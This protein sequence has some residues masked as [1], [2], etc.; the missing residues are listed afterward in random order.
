MFWRN[1]EIVGIDIG[2]RFIKAVEVKESKKGYMLERFGIVPMPPD[3]I[4]DGSILDAPRIV[5]AI[6]QVIEEAKIK[7]RDTVLSVSGHSS[8]IIKRISLAEMTEEELEE[9]IKFEAE[10]YVPFDIEDVNLDFQILGPGEQKDQMDVIIVAVKREKMDEYVATVQEA[11]LRPIIVDVDVFALEN[12]YEINY[13]VEADKNIALVNIGASSINMNIIQNGISIFTRDSAVGSNLHT[14]ALQRE[15]AL[16][17][18]DAERLQ[19]GQSLD[20]ESISIPED[21]ITRVIS[22]ASEDIF[23]E[24]TRSFDY[25]RNTTSYEEIHDVYISGGVALNKDFPVM[26]FEKLGVEPKILQPFKNIQI[27]KHIDKNYL[28]HVEPML[29]VATGLAIRRIGDR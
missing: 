20:S 2:S 24:M 11:G 3:L 25:C 10:Q 13:P 28:H 9:S 4:V 26:L 23:A 27:P 1:K 18:E 12:V 7:A 22:L 8:V 14:E 17:Y 21:E 6:R 15:F 19:T 16:S 5:D 29:A